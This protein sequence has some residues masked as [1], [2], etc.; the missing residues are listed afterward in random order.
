MLDIHMF[1]SADKVAG[2]GV[3]AVYT[4]LVALLKKYFPTEFNVKI[5]DYSASQISHYHTIDPKFYA[6]TFSKR[7]GRKI[8]FV[9]FLPDT[10]DQSLRLPGVARWTLDHYTVAYYKRMDSLVVVNPNFI[11]KLAAYGIDPRKVTYIPNFVSRETFY[12]AT[13]EEKQMLRQKHGVPQDR[14]VVFGAGQVQDRKGVDDFIRLAKRNPKMT[15]IWA[16]GFSF[17]MITNGYD[18]LKGEVENAPA[19]LTF[20]GIVPRE[21]MVDYYNIAD[22]FLLPSFEELFPMSVLEAFSTE[23]PVMVRDLALYDQIIE[24]YA[25]MAKDGDAMNTKLRQLQADA[26]L[27]QTY[28]EKAQQ[29][30][31]EYSEARLARVWH[32]FYL[33]QAAL[34]EAQHESH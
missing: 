25:V 29:A 17:G 1:S 13:A 3:G 11:P 18:H 30:A 6:S 28:T 27:R 14:F 20:T 7:R 24:P 2:Q 10:L 9:H 23:T 31:A 8:G 22:V 4:E 21:E 33:K 32:R 26:N 34:G 15:F 19:N 12:P 5:N 16:G